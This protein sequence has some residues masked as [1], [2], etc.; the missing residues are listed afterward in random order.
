[1]LSPIFYNKKYTYPKILGVIKFN[2]ISKQWRANICALGG[3]NLKNLNKIKM[4][5]ANSIAFISLM[6]ETKIKKPVYY[7]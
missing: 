1:M 2:L 3:I 7:F 4:T 5:K 6:N